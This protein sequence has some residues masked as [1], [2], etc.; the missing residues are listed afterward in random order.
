[1]IR[2]GVGRSF[3]LPYANLSTNANPPFYQV[4]QDV[5]PSNPV[6]NFLANG[7]ISAPPAAPTATGIRSVGL[8]HTPGIKIAPTL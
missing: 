4:T 3:D 7:G 1:M 5:N 6:S 2:G 8:R